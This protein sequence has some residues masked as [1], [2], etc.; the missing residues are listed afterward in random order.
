MSDRIQSPDSPLVRFFQ[1][2][3][4]SNAMHVASITEFHFGQK[5]GTGCGLHMPHCCP[6]CRDLDDATFDCILASIADNP[7][8]ARDR[9]SKALSLLE[10]ARKRHIV[11]CSDY[12]QIMLMQR[13]VKEMDAFAVKLQ[14]I[15]EYDSPSEIQHRWITGEGV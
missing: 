12:V 8:Q 15:R 1:R 14:N 3:L 13:L 5:P 10:K 4:H 7:A 2:R 11:T 6:T 9:I